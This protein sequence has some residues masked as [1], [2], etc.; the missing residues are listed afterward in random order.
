MP[1]PQ[2]FILHLTMYHL[3]P[4]HL[5]M[6]FLTMLCL[7][8]LCPNLSHLDSERYMYAYQCL[9]RKAEER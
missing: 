2:T 6:L 4:L 1:L 7:D 5:I 8:M 9:A 3:T